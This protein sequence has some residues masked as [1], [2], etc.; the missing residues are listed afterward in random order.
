MRLADAAKLFFPH[1][2]VTKH[3]L[4]AAIRNEKLEFIQIG[5]AYYVTEADI[6]DWLGKC[7]ARKK[8]YI[9]GFANGKAASPSGLSL[10]D[11][12]NASLAAALRISKALTKPLPTISRNISGQTQANGDLI[13]FPLQKS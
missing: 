1:G 5:K 10:E 3:T 9:S 7:R 8:G 13:A 2:G 6:Q 11:R 4:L 12:K